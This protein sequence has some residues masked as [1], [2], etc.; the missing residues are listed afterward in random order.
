MER[1]DEELVGELEKEVSK[2][3]LLIDELKYRNVEATIDCV[4]SE[5]TFGSTLPT[6]IYNVKA[7]KIIRPLT[8]I[9]WTGG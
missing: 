6:R 8:P 7:K 1:T 4:I 2:I 9:T 3:N 5:Y